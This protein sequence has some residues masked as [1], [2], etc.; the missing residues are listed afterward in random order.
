MFHEKKLT[1]KFYNN[2]LYMHI[3]RIAKMLKGSARND[4]YVIN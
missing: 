2:S 1:K 4:I 3:T